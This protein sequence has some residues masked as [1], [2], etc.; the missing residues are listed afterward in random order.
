M[1]HISDPRHPEHPSDHPPLVRAG[2]APRALSKMRVSIPQHILHSMSDIEITPSTQQLRGSSVSITSHM[3]PG[4]LGAS[5]RARQLRQEITTA[6]QRR[7]QCRRQCP[8]HNKNNKTQKSLRSLSLLDH[9]NFPIGHQPVTA[10]HAA[11]VS[12]FSELKDPERVLPSFSQNAGRSSSTASKMEPPTYADDL[13]AGPPGAWGNA[14]NKS[15]D[16]FQEKT[17]QLITGSSRTHMPVLHR[18]AC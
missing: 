15:F 4:W 2:T 6:G 13:T 18:V 1:E 5:A 14:R 11:S 10:S 17:K 3:S 8:R 12:Y 9:C 7:S 16:S